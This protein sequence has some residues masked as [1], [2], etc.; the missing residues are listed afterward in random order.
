MRCEYSSQLT[1]NSGAAVNLKRVSQFV[2]K[3][4]G[5][6]SPRSS[7]NELLESAN[8]WSEISERFGWLSARKLNKN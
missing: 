5:S 3:N 8:Y 1:Q 6:M 2:T 7:P 4:T